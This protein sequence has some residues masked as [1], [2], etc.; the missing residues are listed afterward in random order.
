MTNQRLDD[1]LFG[2]LPPHHGLRIDEFI[3][4]EILLREHLRHQN[5]L[6]RMH[7]N[8]KRNQNHFPF[9]VYG[10]DRKTVDHFLTSVANAM[11]KQMAPIRKLVIEPTIAVQNFVLGSVASLSIR[12]RIRG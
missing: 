1:M 8:G 7:C 10:I 2:G 3:E 11:P 9:F 12:A 4:R 6:Y 5:N